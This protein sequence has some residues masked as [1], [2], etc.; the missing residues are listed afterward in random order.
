[1]PLSKQDQAFYEEK[2]G[3]KSFGFMLLATAI[4]GAIMWPSLLYLEDW[5]AGTTSKWSGNV[6]YHLAVIGFLL[7]TVVSVVMYL[8]FKFLLSMGWLPSRR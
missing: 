2:L 6:V 8:G 5:S 4:I 1:M 3:W 7:G